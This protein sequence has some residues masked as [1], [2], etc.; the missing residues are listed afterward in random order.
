MLDRLVLPRVLD[1]WARRNR[2]RALKRSDYLLKQ[3]EIDIRLL[4]DVPRLI[5]R[6][7]RN[8][9]QLMHLLLP[10]VAM[11]II[12][13]SLSILDA[14]NSKIM[15][16][17]SAAI[18]GLVLLPHPMQVFLSDRRLSREREYLADPQAYRKKLIDRLSKLYIAAGMSP[19]EIEEWCTLVPEVPA[20][21]R[22]S[23]PH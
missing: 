6:L 3:F 4:Q 2:V 14:E 9:S 10:L 17:G 7:T 8:V 19:D 12:L 18:V 20:I 23:T 1:W 21:V 16:I 15:F 5:I 22:F 13:L 11:N